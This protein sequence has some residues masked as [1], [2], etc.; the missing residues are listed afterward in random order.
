M[1]PPPLHTTFEPKAVIPSGLLRFG[2]HNE[3]RRVFGG[4]HSVSANSPRCI[5]SQASNTRRAVRYS[6]YFAISFFLS[7]RKVSDG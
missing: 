6:P 1:E 5:Q 3:A 2:A 4:D 7:T